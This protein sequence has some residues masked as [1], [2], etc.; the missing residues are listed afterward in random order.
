[1][2]T[3]SKKPRGRRPSN[4]RPV[5]GSK[6]TPSSVPKDS[7]HLRRTNSI[8][9]IEKAP[10]KPVNQ[11][12]LPPQE[13]ENDIQRVLT[14]EN[15]NALSNTVEFSRSVH[16]GHPLNAYVNV[17][18][19]SSMETFFSLTGPLLSTLP[20]QQEQSNPSKNQ[21][22]YIDRGNQTL[23]Y[24]H[25]KHDAA[26][27]AA[28]TRRTVFSGS[29]SNGFI[30]DAYEHHL[31]P[32]VPD[33]K[34]TKQEALGRSSLIA[35]RMVLQNINSEIISDFQS[36]DHQADL[37]DPTVASLLPLWKLSAFGKSDDLPK[38]KSLRTVTS[39]AWNPLHPDLVAV[40]LGSFDFSIQ[41][42]GA[43]LLFSLKSPH[44]PLSIERLDSGVLSLDWNAEEPWLLGTGL[45]DGRVMVF[46]CHDVGSIKVLA[47]STA[48]TGKHYDC[49]WQVQWLPPI[50]N[51]EDDFV[52]QKLLSIGND[53]RV[54][55][56]ELTR[57]Q[58]KWL[59]K[60]FS[61]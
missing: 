53:G 17:S 30:V 25:P 56:W 19:N 29:V 47:K 26:T 59:P 23:P 40:S 51:D 55:S 34:S 11:L 61:T 43:V 31:N 16:D 32:Q 21:F 48:V 8:I 15:P 46:D 42:G 54:L 14:T 39:M 18:T 38:S 13:L 41:G 7:P 35:E 5:P 60:I 3:P 57:N 36:F 12:N 4:S 2:N 58:S 37:V 10:T 52:C 24:F 33:S 27:S 50:K 49:C 22:N 20:K 6:Q 1:M 45:Y 9:N 44:F 28:E